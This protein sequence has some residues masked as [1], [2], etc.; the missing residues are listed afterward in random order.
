[1]YILVV[2]MAWGMHVLT[3]NM[4]I[5]TSVGNNLGW[6]KSAPLVSLL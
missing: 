5:F 1:M 4:E 2:K 6:A 3:V